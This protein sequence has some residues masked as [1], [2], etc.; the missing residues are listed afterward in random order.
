MNKTK[1]VIMG[2]FRPYLSARVPKMS[3]PT[4]RSIKVTVM[5]QV[6]DDG[7]TLNSAAISVTHNETVK[8]S[9]EHISLLDC[10]R[11]YDSNLTKRI[12]RPPEE[13]SKKHQ[14]LVTV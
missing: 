11:L 1:Q 2:H 5:P 3:A 4:E 6:T 9:E 8:K 10:L 13:T 12:P 7:S 14:P